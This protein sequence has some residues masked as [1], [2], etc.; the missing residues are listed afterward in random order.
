[1]KH[2]AP[3]RKALGVRTIFNILGPLTN[4]AH[5]THQL[6][7]VYSKHLVEQ[8]AHVLKNLGSDRAIVVHA[9]MVWMRSP[10][11]TRPCER[12]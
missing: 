1:M 11:S 9:R 3:V 2:V 4:P 5:A 7:G 12:A 8:M 10:Q 6:M